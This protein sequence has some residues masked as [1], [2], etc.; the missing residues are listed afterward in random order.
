VADLATGDL[1][2][3]K[4]FLITSLIA[5]FIVGSLSTTAV[6]SNT[7]KSCAYA[8]RVVSLGK[9]PTT[10]I[11]E[12]FEIGLCM[13]QLDSGIAFIS[14]LPLDKGDQTCYINIPDGIIVLTF[15]AVVDRYLRA[16]PE[17]M[18][19]DFNLVMVKAAESTWSCVSKRIM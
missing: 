4:G 1:I 16:H 7:G 10:K 9:Y 17:D 3:K 14:S 6:A 8:L 18:D 2:M 11:K 12:M 15:A 19:E 5:M 13:G